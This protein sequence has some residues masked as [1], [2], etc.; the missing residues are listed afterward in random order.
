MQTQRIDRE[1]DGEKV[2]TGAQLRLGWTDQLVEYEVEGSPVA[3]KS[4]WDALIAANRTY[5]YPRYTKIRGHLP[6]GDKADGDGT[7]G[8]LGLEDVR[9]MTLRTGADGDGLSGGPSAGLA[10]PATGAS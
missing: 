4:V 7:D 6:G 10:T 3:I 1:I 8:S 9:R 5:Q 2:G